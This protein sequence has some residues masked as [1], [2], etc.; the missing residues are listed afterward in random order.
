MMHGK[1]VALVLP[2]YNAEPTLERTWAEV[3]KDDVDVV[4]LV[5]DASDDGTV[6]IARRLGIRVVIHEENRGY[7]ANQKTC[8]REALT[9][10]ADVVVMLHPDYQYDPRLLPYLVGLVA[11]GVCDVVLG[12]RIR[13]R[14]EALAGGMPRYKY[15]A[16][17]FLTLVENLATGENLGEWH[18]GLR[19]YSAQCLGCLRWDENSDDFVFDQQ[20]LFQASAARF[21]LADVPCPARYLDEASSISFRRSTRYGL[22]TLWYCL[23]YVLHRSGALRCALY[24]PRQQ[25]GDRTETIRLDSP[26]GSDRT[27]EPA[28]AGADAAAERREAPFR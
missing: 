20:L 16:N 12:N 13:T 22:Q 18:S 8:Y 25:A 28:A 4:I 24:E 6:E 11:E 19:A 1:K 14:Q 7:G 5:D 21:R 23:R 3:P 26:T 9:H 17:R 27:E 15:L 10:G 2:A